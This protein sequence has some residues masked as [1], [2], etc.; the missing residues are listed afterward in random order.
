M[1][2][3]NMINVDPYPLTSCVF[4]VDAYVNAPSHD[5]ELDYSAR[6]CSFLRYCLVAGT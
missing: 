2:T 5:V 3:Q 4:V 6:G 1:D